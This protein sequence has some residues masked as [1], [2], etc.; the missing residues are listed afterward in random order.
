M[1]IL[2]KITYIHPDKEILFSGIDFVVNKGEKV[3][4]VGNNGSGKSTLL[5]LIVNKVKPV[6]G[7]IATN[8]VIYYVPQILDQFNNSTV[9]QAMQVAKKLYALK[10]IL[11][12]KVNEIN[13][14]VLGDSWDLEERCRE[15]LDFWGLRNVNP[16][17]PM[18]LLSGG[19]QTKVL[20]AGIIVHQPDMVLLDE[21]TNHLDRHA[22]L[23][24]YEWLKAT[25]ITVI[26]VSHDR[27]LLNMV[28]RISEISGTGIANYGG[29]YQFYIV[30]KQQESD[31]LQN[32][33]HSKALALKRAKAKER[34]T[35]ERQ[36]KLDARGKG[37]KE[38][39]G[40]ARIMLNTF[41]NNA[42]NS[43]AKTKEAHAEKIQGIAEELRDLRKD[44]PGIDKMDFD[45]KDSALHKGKILFEAKELNFRYVD[46]DVWP[47]ALNFQIISS[48]R[49]ALQGNNGS[50]KSTLIKLLTGSLLHSSGSLYS[51]SKNIVYV[52]QDYS[53]LNNALTVFEQ[54]QR[55]NTSG[56]PDHEIRM[57]L[58]RFLFSKH[59]ID[60]LCG[61]LSGG[62]RM[63]LVLCCI[64]MSQTPLDVLV[65]DEPT[66][67]LDIQNIEILTEAVN[68]FKG[69]LLVVSHDSMFL[70][71]IKTERIISL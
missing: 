13:L 38:K 58:N 67:N 15:A 55:A 22:R 26:A 14:E 59:S 21:P 43:S 57:R 17:M 62:E 34:E 24:L 47:S 27:E 28:N 69:T 48:D 49:V 25:S 71:S 63:R 66:N 53:Y 23:K 39:S 68:Q 60:K 37:K 12:G 9:A 29:N 51:A 18:A 50:G 54:A 44:S 16:N 30:Q 32:E 52:D 36:Q 1:L 42:E 10:Q 31:A 20:L 7:T 70:E 8:A 35:N 40:V 11:N 33:I 5:K 56:L 61:V 2:Q 46:I 4:V 64:T 3:A 19:Q 65:L 45:F 6:S 41:K